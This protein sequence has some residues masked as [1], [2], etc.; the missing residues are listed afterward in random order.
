[1]AAI[2]VAVGVGRIAPGISHATSWPYEILGAGYAL[3]AV[4]F[5]V[6]AYL[7]ARSVEDA[8]DSGGFAPL[9]AALMLATSA[10]GVVLAVATVVVLVLVH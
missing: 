6:F 7:R 5:V 9:P 2:A 8:L 1:L 3:L 4:A 10:A